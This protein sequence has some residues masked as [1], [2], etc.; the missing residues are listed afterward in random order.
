[1]SVCI[2]WICA[3]PEELR[4]YMYLHILLPSEAE[5]VVLHMIGWCLYLTTNAM[6]V[7]SNDFAM[8]V[9]PVV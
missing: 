3:S 6:T 7:Y 2:N 5:N 8:I 4:T 9:L 1:M